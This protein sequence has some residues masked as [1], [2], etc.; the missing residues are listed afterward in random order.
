MTRFAT[1]FCTVS[2]VLCAATQASAVCGDVNGSGTLTAGDALAVLKASVGQSVNLQCSGAGGPLKTGQT[3]CY[4]QAGGQIACDDSGEDGQL[5]KGAA[6][7]YTDNGDGTI[8]DNATGLTWEKLSDDGSIHDKDNTYTWN[9]ALG[10]VASLNAGNFAGHN[11]WRLPNL[12][13][14]QTLMMVGTSQPA[15]A[16]QFRTACSAGCSVTTCSCTTSDWYWSSTTYVDT[17]SE[18]WFIDFTNGYTDTD[19]KTDNLNFAR[20]VRGGS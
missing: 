20:A 2:L 18:A 17:T 6:R 4:D 1:V 7:S 3:T 13:E 15:I 8:T 5:Q 16:S 19:T 11:D 9:N 14:L 10:K 12:D